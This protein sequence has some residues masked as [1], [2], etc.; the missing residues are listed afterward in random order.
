MPNPPVTDKKNADIEK[1]DYVATKYR[2][3]THE[4]E[5]SKEKYLLYICTVLYTNARIPEVKLINLI[6]R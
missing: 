6:T 2:G 5:V 4:G 3:G 1:G